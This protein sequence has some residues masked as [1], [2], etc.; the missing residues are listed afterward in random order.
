MKLSEHEAD[1]SHPPS[2]KVKDEASC[3][4]A[5]PYASRSAKYNKIIHLFSMVLPDSVWKKA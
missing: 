2:V 3:F 1:H 4:Y 5:P